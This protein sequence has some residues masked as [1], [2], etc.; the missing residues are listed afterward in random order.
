MLLLLAM[1]YDKVITEQSIIVQEKTEAGTLERDDTL[2]PF[3]PLIDDFFWRVENAPAEIEWTKSTPKVLSVGCFL[4]F[5]VW[6]YLY[7]SKKNLI[8][9]KEYGTSRW[10]TKKDIL[11]LSAKKIQ[12]Q[13]IKEYK[14]KHSF[15]FIDKIFEVFALIFKKEKRESFLDTIALKIDEINKIF[16]GN[17]KWNLKIGQ[18]YMALKRKKDDAISDIKSK[19][20][21]WNSIIFTATEKFCMYN[22]ELNNNVVIVGGSGSGKTRGYVLPNI[23]NCCLE[24]LGFSKRLWEKLLG[25]FGIKSQ[26]NYQQNKFSPSLVVTDPKGEILAKVGKPLE[27]SGYEIKVLNLKEQDRSFCFNPFHYVME[28]KFEEQISCLIDSIMNAKEDEESAGNIDPFW[29]EMAG[30]LLTAIAYAIYEAFPKEKQTMETLLV[31]FRWFEVSDNDDRYRNPTKLDS[32]FADIGDKYGLYNTVKDILSFYNKYY[33]S[34][35]VELIGRETALNMVD[36]EMREN[37]AI[38]IG[39]SN[40]RA[41]NRYADEITEIM[42]AVRLQAEENDAFKEIA[43]DLESLSQKALE[44]ITEY[45]QAR[46]ENYANHKKP[47]GVEVFEKYGD[48][49]ENPALRSWEDF[50]TKCK[51]KTAQSVTSTA[52]SKLKPFDEKEIRRI[53]SKD[54]M[55]LDLVGERKTAL[56]IVLP[57][58]KKRYNFIANILYINLFEQLEYCATV[59][60]DQHLPVPVRII[61]DEWYNTGKIP[62]FVNILSYARSFGIGITIILQSLDQIKELYE[63]SWGTILDNCSYFLYLGGIRHN[64]TLEYVSKLTGK[65]T[66]DKRSYSH[67]KGARQSSATISDDKIGRELLDPAEVGRLKKSRCLLY[68]NGYHTFNSK[69]FNYKKHK[70]YK[71]TSDYSKKNLYVYKTPQE[72]ALEL[73]LKEEIT[74]KEKNNLLAESAKSTIEKLQKREDVFLN[75]NIEENMK[76]ISENPLNYMVV[77]VQTEMELTKMEDEDF[78]KFF[79]ENLKE[80][81]EKDKKVNAELIKKITYKESPELITLEDGEKMINAL[82][83]MEEMK[84]T[85]EIYSGSGEEDE[86]IVDDEEIDAEEIK[87]IIQENIKLE[88]SRLESGF[89]DMFSNLDVSTLES[90]TSVDEEIEFEE[91]E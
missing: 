70:N 26:K 72:K 50:R 29:E 63:K 71:Q 8:T 59:K 14:G 60:H 37:L 65:G 69:K 15:D 62:N 55:E 41:I 75:T 51:G 11:H 3:I 20:S 18:L 79:E 77:D 83:E 56:F 7:T 4:I 46:L 2:F 90:G 10:G 54:E 48:V 25:F 44:S 23:L 12:K 53:F 78:A 6:G 64:D 33:K 84:D 45:K 36:R 9:N 82:K 19:F 61:C 30:V 39:S 74:Q 58:I 13:N 42:N 32:F 91:E 34:G 16:K 35:A 1:S 57:P 76:E 68:V 27:E 49:N 87:A 52:L 88:E 81:A 80:E 40:A 43:N 24:K 21:D 17:T 66:F 67:T 5:V 22:F 89:S 86:W 31:L 28:E 38:P 47:I 85:L 73:L